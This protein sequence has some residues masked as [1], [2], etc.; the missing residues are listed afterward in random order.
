MVIDAL[1]LPEEGEPEGA[2]RADLVAFVQALESEGISVVLVEELAPAS[3]LAEPLSRHHRRRDVSC[4]RQYLNADI[5]TRHG[6][7]KGRSTCVCT[8]TS[9]LARSG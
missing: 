4:V 3:L 5:Q 1:T 8:G 6:P 7:V 9:S 2:L